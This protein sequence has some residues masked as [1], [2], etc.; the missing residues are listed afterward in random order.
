T[1]LHTPSLPDALPIFRSAG[2]RAP[3]HDLERQARV[4]TPVDPPT[5]PGR[6]PLEAAP[7][8]EAEVGHVEDA[9]AVVVEAA[10]RHPQARVPVAR[11]EEHTSELQSRE[12]L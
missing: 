6:E 11:S 2:D 3:I 10:G 9:A 4:A 8:E 5:V 7:G 12:K 1:A